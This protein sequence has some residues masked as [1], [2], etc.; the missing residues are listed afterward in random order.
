MSADDLSD[1]LTEKPADTLE[2]VLVRDFFV[3]ARNVGK[4]PSDAR[5][6]VRTVFAAIEGM[7]SALQKKILATP[8]VDLSPE[9]RIFL[10]GEQF[11]L[12]DSG[13]IR[14]VPAKLTLEQRVRFVTAIFKRM[15]PEYEIDFRDAGWQSLLSSLRVR[16]RLTHPSERAALNVTPQELEDVARA[17]GW[18]IQ[19]LVAQGQEVIVKYLASDRAKQAMLVD[20]IR[21][22]RQ[23]P[24]AE[25]AIEKDSENA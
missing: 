15:H 4:T 21:K 12:D 6:Y 2:L 23:V 9:E 25:G 19:K 3:A 14:I 8:G 13:T 10:K 24:A 5:N 11:R 18:F 22:R 16:H 7:T 20:A 17:A 1:F